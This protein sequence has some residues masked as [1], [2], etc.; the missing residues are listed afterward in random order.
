MKRMMFTLFVAV[1]ALTVSAGLSM[2]QSCC[3][4]SAAP[5]YNRT[6][7]APPQGYGPNAGACLGSGLNCPVSGSAG[8]SC[9][10]GFS[11]SQARTANY[12][13]PVRN[14]RAY[15]ADRGVPRPI[16]RRASLT[17][18]QADNSSLPPCCQGSGSPSRNLQV[19]RWTEYLPKISQALET[20]RRL[21]SARPY[22]AQPVL[23]RPQQSPARPI[24]VASSLLQ[25]PPRAAQASATT[26][27]YSA[28]Q[29]GANSTLPPCCQT[30]AQTTR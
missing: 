29:A 11:A 2:A 19:K 24:T 25:W 21:P 1:L 13:G 20:P 4:G 16:V 22:K 28:P 7:A 18:E 27:D 23:E 30:G 26:A 17:G 3:G 5:Q 10:G 8:A 14:P 6:L 15:V 12:R 9:C